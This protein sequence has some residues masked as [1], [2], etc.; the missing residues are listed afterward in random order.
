[1]HYQ[2]VLLVLT[3]TVVGSSSSSRS[4]SSGVEHVEA[5]WACS[6]HCAMPDTGRTVVTG[7]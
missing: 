1:M 2:S 6:Q 7:S 3:V 4:S 5:V